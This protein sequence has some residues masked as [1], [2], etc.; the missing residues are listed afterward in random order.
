LPPSL[1]LFLRGY[2]SKREAEALALGRLLSEN[3]LVF[4]KV[5]D[6]PLDPGTVSHSFSRMATIVMSPGSDKLVLAG[7]G[8]SGDSDVAPIQPAFGFQ[9]RLPNAS[10]VFSRRSSSF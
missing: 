5:G 10:P 9:A 2:R 4:S 1:A 7:F 6:E 8:P 3:D